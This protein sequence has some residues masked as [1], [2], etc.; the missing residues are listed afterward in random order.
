MSMIIGKRKERDKTIYPKRKALGHIKGEP[1]HEWT[2][3]VVFT[4]FVMLEDRQQSASAI[5]MQYRPRL[6]RLLLVIQGDYLV[7]TYH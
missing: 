2:T 7:V 1:R 4:H 3:E 6:S 5:M